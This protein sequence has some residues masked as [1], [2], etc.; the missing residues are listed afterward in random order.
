[1][2][3]FH[4]SVSVLLFAELREIMTGFFPILCSLA[5]LAA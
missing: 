2:L 5:Q 1:M 3:C 4:C